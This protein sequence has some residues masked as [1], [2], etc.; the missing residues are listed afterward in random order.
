MGKRVF[1]KLLFL[2][3]IVNLSSIT[4]NFT[5]KRKF[6]SQ[7]TIEIKLIIKKKHFDKMNAID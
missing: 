4:G 3:L 5:Y 7:I 1:I 2:Y 6:L